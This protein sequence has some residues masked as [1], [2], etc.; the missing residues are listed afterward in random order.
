MP[1][2]PKLRSS[3]ISNK[4]SGSTRIRS[5]TR[6][7]VSRVIQHENHISSIERTKKKNSLNS[8]IRGVRTGHPSHGGVFLPPG[9]DILQHG[10]ALL[11]SR[12]PQIVSG[13]F[14]HLALAPPRN[15]P[16][17]PATSWSKH[18]NKVNFLPDARVN[19]AAIHSRAAVIM[20]CVHISAILLGGEALQESRNRTENNWLVVLRGKFRQERE[21]EW[22]WHFLNEA[23]NIAI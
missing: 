7:A 12:F 13:S 20:Q 22:L 6:R 4:F 19:F 17:R 8:R 14:D 1:N 5:Y 9:V 2:T 21:R 10:G 11:P 15:P 3:N 18:L 16:P 23:A